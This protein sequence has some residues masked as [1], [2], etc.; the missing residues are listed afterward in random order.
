M[1]W[2]LKTTHILPT[3]TRQPEVHRIEAA[4]LTAAIAQAANIANLALGFTISNRV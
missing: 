2:T 1:T 4:S 3:G